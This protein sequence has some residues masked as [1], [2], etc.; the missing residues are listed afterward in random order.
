MK[1]RTSNVHEPLE[2]G[3]HDAVWLQ[4]L[5]NKLGYRVDIK[6]AN[7]TLTFYVKVFEK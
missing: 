2:I 3:L 4:Q 7:K 6:P 5:M 1:K